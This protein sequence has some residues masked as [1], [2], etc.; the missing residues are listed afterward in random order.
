MHLPVT[1]HMN[2]QKVETIAL[3][4]SG[5]I[6]IFIDLVFAKEHNLQICN[7]WTEI[8][9]MNVDGMKNQDGSIREYVTANL[10]VKG[11]QKDTQFLV[12]ALG[13]Q[14]V[15]LGYPW[16]VE[17]NP[18][19]DWREQKFS[20][21]KETPKVNIYE[22]MLEIQRQ[23]EEDL[24]DLDN[25]LVIAFVQGKPGNEH[26]LTDEWI[27]RQLDP[28][29]IQ[30]VTFEEKSM[31]V[32]EQWIQDKMT[33]SQY[34]KNVEREQK[35]GK[36]PEDLVPKEFHDFLST[37]FSERPIGTLPT[38]KPY[39]HAID[40]KP[41]F[42]PVI[43]K[44]FRLDQKQNEAVRTFIQENINKGFIRPSHSPQTSTLFFV[45]KEDG[46][47]HLVQ[48]Y[49]YLNSQ[50]ICN[51]YPLPRIDKLINNLC[52][53]DC[54]IKMDIHWGYKN[55]CIKEGDEW[56]AAFSCCEGSFEPLVMFFGLTNSPA[57]FQ[58]MM[59]DIFSQELIQRWLKIYMDDL[60]ICG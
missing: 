14:K 46:K 32:T 56:K 59:N 1:L 16:L 26:E 13:T 2:G 3:I 12:T 55:V 42:K 8:A 47:S 18:K 43:Q 27:E 23:V 17:A 35:R 39:D 54:Y 51:G 28:L 34:L 41:D 20:W 31:N 15:I 38:R 57:T 36:K 40:L 53:Y 52:E 44:P 22:I 19:I 21:W 60:L 49:H 48:D 50:T 7:L 10:E 9:V 37:V 5:A 6:G 24:Y 4:D 11:R 25:E 45:S 33:K 29:V 58:A 30:S